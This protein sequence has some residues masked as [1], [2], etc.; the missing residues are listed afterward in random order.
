MVRRLLL[1]TVLKAVVMHNKQNQ[2]LLG[3]RLEV[4][5]ALAVASILPG[6]KRKA[7]LETNLSTSLFSSLS[8]A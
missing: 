5:P 8:T 6:E 4:S 3:L 7:Q 1:L 2:G